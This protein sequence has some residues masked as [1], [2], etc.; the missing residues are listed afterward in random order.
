MHTYCYRQHFE[1]RKIK[2]QCHNICIATFLPFKNVYTLVRKLQTKIKTNMFF[3]FTK[4][5][6]NSHHLYATVQTYTTIMITATAWLIIIR[7]LAYNLFVSASFY[8]LDP[9]DPQVV[10]TQCCVQPCSSPTHLVHRTFPK[11]MI[12]VLGF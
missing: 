6:Y 8:S 9:H 5:L 4:N 12:H 2:P 3:S 1:K 11:W 7:Y 10:L